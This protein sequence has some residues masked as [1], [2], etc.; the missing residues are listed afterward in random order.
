MQFHKDTSVSFPLYVIKDFLPDPGSY[1]E[2]VLSAPTASEKGFWV[3]EN[4]TV[5]GSLTDKTVSLVFNTAERILND[6]IW[7]PQKRVF[8]RR[9]YEAK[10]SELVA[11]MD[12]LK[13]FDFDQRGRAVYANYTYW[14]LIFDF[15][16]QDRSAKL[17]FCRHASGEVC[18]NPYQSS[19]TRQIS[20]QKDASQWKAYKDFYYAYNTAIMFPAHY[21]HNASDFLCSKSMPRTMGVCWFFSGFNPKYNKCGT[22]VIDR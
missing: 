11:H 4:V 19:H 22:P 12:R 5:P 21:W 15:T 17:S 20:V 7:I 1:R 18:F 8:F 14:S 2:T 13:D 16:P 9:L 10:P 6:Y 3:G